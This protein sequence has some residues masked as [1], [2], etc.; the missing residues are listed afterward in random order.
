MAGEH[1]TMIVCRHCGGDSPEGSVF[2]VHCGRTLGRSRPTPVV[3]SQPVSGGAERPTVVDFGPPL[4][5]KSPVDPQADTLPPDPSRKRSKAL[6]LGA[7]ARALRVDASNG[8]PPEPAALAGVTSSS[9]ALAPG[10]PTSKPPSMKALTEEEP[11]PFSESG[12][13]AVPLKPGAPLATAPMMSRLSRAEAEIVDAATLTRTDSVDELE[14]EDGSLD[15]FE[16]AGPASLS[17]T[18]PPVPGSLPETGQRTSMVSALADIDI[19][20]PEESALEGPA[21]EASPETAALE[22]GA[23]VSGTPE[24]EVSVAPGPPLPPEPTEAL[25]H[26]G[27]TLSS[28]DI[29]PVENITSETEVLQTGDFEAIDLSPPLEAARPMPPPLPEAARFTLRALSTNLDQSF[30]VAVPEKGISVGRAQADVNVE[31]DP[32]MSPRHASFIPDEVGVVVE[33]LNSHNG[34]W[35]RV[36]GEIEVSNGQLFMIG[37]QILRAGRVRAY[38]SPEAAE[39]GTR[40]LRLSATPGE[41]Q[42]EQIDVSGNTLSTHRLNEGGCRLGRHVGDWVFTQDTFLSGIHA[43]LLPRDNHLVLRDLGSRNGVW[44]KVVSHQS[45][46]PGDAVM[47]GQTILRLGRSAG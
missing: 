44:L 29:E 27:E 7:V 20:D 47:M 22:T 41:W 28:L 32:F 21:P 36:R 45:L 33:D 39:D 37:Q 17:E 35:L 23:P 38:N 4:A 8:G 26:E 43:L 6:D 11:E 24:T 5:D 30:T 13:V 15:E 46:R 19:P 31:G 42:L 34:I 40:P 12:R 9:S 16:P 3:Q 18:G 1:S 25:L 2:C 14:L 10:A